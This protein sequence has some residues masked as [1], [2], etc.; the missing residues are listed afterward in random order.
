[1]PAQLA[2][3]QTAIIGP[4]EPTDCA[5]FVAAQLSAQHTTHGSAVCRTILAAIG[6]TISRADD[7]AELS[8]EQSADRVPIDSTVFSTQ[9]RTIY[10]THYA[11]Y[12]SAFG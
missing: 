12:A 7:A 4:F 1:M 3:H 8:A 2:T 5:P 6:T 11:D 9:C 10:A